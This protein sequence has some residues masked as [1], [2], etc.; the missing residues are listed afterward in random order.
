M[1]SSASASF[2]LIEWLFGSYRHDRWNRSKPCQGRGSTKLE[3]TDKYEKFSWISRILR[4]VY[5]G[6]FQDCQ[7]ID[8]INKEEWKVPLDERI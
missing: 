1:P 7:T 8:T 4:E 6:L 2:S 5:S 3:S